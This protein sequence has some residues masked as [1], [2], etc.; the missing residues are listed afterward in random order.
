MKKLLISLLVVLLLTAGC[1]QKVENEE[2]VVGVV[3]EHYKY[4]QPVID[5]LSEEGI[6]LTLKVFNEYSIPNQA[7]AQ[8]EI[9]MNAFQ[10]YLYLN[11]EIKEFNYDLA[12]LAETIIDPLGIYS[13]KY[14]NMNE[15]TENSLVVIPDDVT[16]GGRALKLLEAAGMI[17][18]DPA[19]GYLP[20]ILDIREN[21][22]NLQVKNV[23]AD[24]IPSMLSDVDL[25]VINGDLAVSYGKKPAQ[26]SIF[27]EEVDSKKNPHVKDLINILVVRKEDLQNPNY[28]KVKEYFQS[29]EVINIMDEYYNKAF[30]PAWK[31]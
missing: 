8:K 2:I 27:L 14:K 9:H 31:H 22:L 21:N 3:G 26:D 19:K 15:V 7:L 11:Q 24:L 18:V 28:L 30:I 5:K 13:D 10:H 17:K 1:A 4:W 20:S 6:T 16:N 23:K 25:A 29:E 12:V